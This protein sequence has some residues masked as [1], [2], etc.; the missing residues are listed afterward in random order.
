MF[1]VIN[2]SNFAQIDLSGAQEKE[3]TF[4]HKFFLRAS[5]WGNTCHTCSIIP[6][7]LYWG[8]GLCLIHSKGILGWWSRCGMW[9]LISKLSKSF[10]NESDLLFLVHHWGRLTSDLRGVSGPSEVLLCLLI[11]IHTGMHWV[12]VH[13]YWL[14]PTYEAWLH[15]YRSSCVSWLSS[16]PLPVWWTV[17]NEKLSRPRVGEEVG[18]AKPHEAWKNKQQRQGH[19]CHHTG[20]IVST[21]KKHTHQCQCW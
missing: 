8:L 16:S 13:T 2:V 4:H 7:C 20:L 18:V 12:C 17:L 5:K 10:Y 19:C 6:K 9:Y 1:K 21:W 3:G 11:K 14:M 15:V